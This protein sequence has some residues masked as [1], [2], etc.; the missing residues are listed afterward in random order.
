MPEPITVLGFDFGTSW[1]GTAI[2]QTQTGTASPLNAIRVINNNPDW[3]NIA[4]LIKTWKPGRLIVGLPLNET[5]KETGICSLCKRFSR[6]LEG[7]FHIKT[8]MIN[9]RLTTREA[10]QIL[11]EKANNRQS[12]SSIDCIAA[13]LITE[14]WL[15]TQ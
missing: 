11:E 14:T 9:E 10:W 12:K 13:V 2:G 5:G 4:T 3:E 1:I 15:S 8:E 7:R 6:Q